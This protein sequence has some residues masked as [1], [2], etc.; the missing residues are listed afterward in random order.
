MAILR[1]GLSAAIISRA[2]SKN[3]A[4]ADEAQLALP[5]FEHLPKRI[6]AHGEKIAFTNAT[7]TQF[8]AYKDR[9]ERRAEKDQE[10]VNELRK[11]ALL[12]APY[13]QSGI[14]VVAGAHGKRA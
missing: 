8:L 7:V 13:A 9:Y 2:R 5:G 14:T 6:S 3:S 11:L 1:D 10:T 12:V 4:A